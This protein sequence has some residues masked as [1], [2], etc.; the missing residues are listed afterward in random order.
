MIP[1]PII[2]RDLSSANVLLKPTSNGGWLAKVSDYGTA[3]FQS[4]LQ[5]INPG[6]PVYTAPESREP[7][8]QTPKMD[9]YSFGVLLI[10]MCTCEFPVP[11]CRDKLLKSIK[12]PQ[13]LDLITQCLSTDQNQRPTAARLINRL[14][15][16]QQLIIIH[17]PSLA[18]HYIMHISASIDSVHMLNLWFY[19]L[20]PL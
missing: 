3:N 20:E 15:A 6:C 18:S 19:P 4:Q 14:Q 11:E 5:T 17:K 8:L 13:L 10:E 12:H 2:H 9:I 1:E 7:A 16:M